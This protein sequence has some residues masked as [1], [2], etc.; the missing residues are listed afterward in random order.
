MIA[1]SWRAATGCFLFWIPKSVMI[2]SDRGHAPGA[3]DRL[4]ETQ[5]GIACIV[6]YRR[7]VVSGLVASV[8]HRISLSLTKQANSPGEREVVTWMSIR[9]RKGVIMTSFTFTKDA[10]DFVDRI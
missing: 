7:N 3:I 10:L 6:R 5:T 4:I 2:T 9:A 1:R 8:P